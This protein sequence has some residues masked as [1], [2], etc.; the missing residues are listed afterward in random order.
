MLPFTFLWFRLIRARKLPRKL[1]DLRK[2][3]QQ[4]HREL[5]EARAMADKLTAAVSQELTFGPASNQA[6]KAK[7]SSPA[8][9]SLAKRPSS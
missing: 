3:V 6:L 4:L 7:V 2:R 1:R 8:A 9:S 5:D